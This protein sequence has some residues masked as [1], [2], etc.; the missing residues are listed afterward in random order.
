MSHETF[1]DKPAGPKVLAPVC[2]S[3]SSDRA[4]DPWEAHG[5]K[6]LLCKQT[7]QDATDRKSPRLKKQMSQPA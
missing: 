3:S 6:F 5:G 1:R 4:L 2:A 7:Q